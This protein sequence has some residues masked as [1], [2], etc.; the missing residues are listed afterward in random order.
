MKDRTSLI[1]YTWCSAC[2]FKNVECQSVIENVIAYLFIYLFYM[3]LLYSAPLCQRSLLTPRAQHSLSHLHDL[4]HIEGDSE[5]TWPLKQNNGSGH[6]RRFAH[7]RCK[8]C[9][10]VFTLHYDMYFYTYCCFC[11]LIWC[12]C[13]LVRFTDPPTPERHREKHDCR[14]DGC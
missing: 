14:I 12:C 8:Y 10:L 9:W 4:T 13:C 3:T 11:D 5:I 1:F 7:A 6:C 2:Y